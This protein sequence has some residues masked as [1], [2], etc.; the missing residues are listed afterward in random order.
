VEHKNQK[1]F[2]RGVEGLTP[3][4][5]KQIKIILVFGRNLKEI[6]RRE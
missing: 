5:H 2:F 4:A 1:K 6:S 3:T